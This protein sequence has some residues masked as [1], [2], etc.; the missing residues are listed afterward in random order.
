MVSVWGPVSLLAPQLYYACATQCT[1]LS[2]A[3][4]LAG[5]NVCCMRYPPILLVLGHRNV[6]MSTWVWVEPDITHGN[7]KL[8]R[9]VTGSRRGALGRA[10]S[11]DLR[12]LG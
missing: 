5:W 2:C 10:L 7:L 11:N 8:S 9:L 6:E 4:L 12:I 3:C 1:P